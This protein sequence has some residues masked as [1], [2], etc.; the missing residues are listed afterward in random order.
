MH[1]AHKLFQHFYQNNNLANLN[2][3]NTTLLA[4]DTLTSNLEKKVLKKTKSHLV[5][6][7]TLKKI[8]HYVHEKKKSRNTKFRSDPNNHKAT[9]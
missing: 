9:E 4:I 1:A 2:S 6:V 8:K 7:K 5:R 3:L